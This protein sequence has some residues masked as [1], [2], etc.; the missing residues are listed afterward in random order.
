M[1]RP[2]DV[3]PRRAPF[4]LVGG[5]VG[6]RTGQ[7]R[8]R[9]GAC[10]AMGPSCRPL[11]GPWPRCT[12]SCGGDASPRWTAS[13][14]WPTSSSPAAWHLLDRVKQH[15]LS[16]RAVPAR[17]SSTRSPGSPLGARRDRAGP[18][19]RS[20]GEGAIAD[21]LFVIVDA[22]EPRPPMR[23]ATWNVA[24]AS[25]P[26]SPRGRVA[27]LRP[28]RLLCMPE[29]K[30]ADSTFPAMAFLRPGSVD[31]A[32]RRPLER[33]RPWSAGSGSATWRRGSTDHRS[34]PRGTP[35]RRH[36]RRGAGPRRVVPDGRSVDSGAYVGR[37]GVVRRL[38]AH[39]RPGPSPPRTRWRV[40]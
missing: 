21:L 18:T 29:T 27:R 3:L 2:E 38:R 8:R 19:P 20:T 34:T 12:G 15:P 26:G 13:P 24:I 11:P 31:L 39:L 1:V 23:I 16:P 30:V 7:A 14:C 28:T 10:G 4:L 33:C 25:T 32:R 17:C 35:A 22:E 6:A 36:L 40:Q 9:R 5:V 37:V